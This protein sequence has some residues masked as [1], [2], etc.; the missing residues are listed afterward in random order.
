MA[1]LV[2]GE[3]TA[4]SVGMD[5]ERLQRLEQTAARWVADGETPSMVL[6]VARHGTIVLHHA[7]GVRHYED[8]APTLRTDAIFPI[9]SCTKPITAALV[10]CLVEDGLIGLNR[11]VVEYV[12]ELASD[13]QWLEEVKVA[14]LLCHTAC[15]DDLQWVAHV[16]AAANSPD[17]PPPA[18]G[19][20][21]TI[22]RRIRLAN[23]APLARR[24]GSALL[25]SNF[26]YQL[27]GDIV[28]RVSGQPLWQF[29]QSRLFG[30][31]GM[32]DSYFRL[33]P[34][35]RARRVY[36]KPGFPSTLPVPG[37][38][39]GLDSV[40]FD[41][42]DLGSNGV[43]STAHDMAVF[44]QTLLNGGCYGQARVLSRATVAAMA[45]LQVDPSIPALATFVDPVTRKQTEF[46]FKGGGYGF[47]LFLYVRPDR[48]A[49]N[50]SLAS[51]QGFGHTGY[52]GVYMFADPEYELIGVCLSVSPRIKQGFP[53]TNSDLFMNAVYGAIAD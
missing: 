37:L 44:L 12:P 34:E 3:G 45:R 46:E 24:P 27:L 9:A 17:L 50:G 26:G 11:S 18:P 16:N 4:R 29:A 15:M 10:M 40:E 41:E 7:F 8:A 32:R 5:P 19:Q 13:V 47:G 31:L 21:P 20:H 23:G 48:F 43:A 33:P 22:N 42:L 25:Y 1:N 38:H 49:T 51:Q 2:L 52:H 36:R 28:R 6:L 53:A 35:L 14:D 39:G 30:P